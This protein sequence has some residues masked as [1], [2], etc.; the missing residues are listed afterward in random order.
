MDDPE[1]VWLNTQVLAARQGSDEAF[2]LLVE[3]YQKPV[4]NLC[5]RML[6]D[7]SEAEDAAQESFWRAYQSLKKYD[8]QRSFATWLLAISAHYCIDQIRKRRMVVLPMD[9]LREE[10]APD[11][12]PGPETHFS[13]A[14]EREAIQNILTNLNPKDRAAIIMRYWYELSY[15]EISEALSLSVSAV[16]SRLHRARID[17]AELWQTKQKIPAKATRSQYESPA[18]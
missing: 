13:Q 5:Y 16:K 1:I 7:P 4:Y 8:P 2:E 15:E 10:D 17:L 9:V 6:G 11:L 12:T 14:E 18:I 3:K